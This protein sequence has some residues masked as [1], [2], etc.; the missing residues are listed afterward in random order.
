MRANLWLQS[1]F[2]KSLN[3]NHAV[4]VIFPT[5]FKFTDQKTFFMQ[6]TKYFKTLTQ[7]IK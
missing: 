1:L 3:D 6:T 4:E 2:N 5:L 7:A